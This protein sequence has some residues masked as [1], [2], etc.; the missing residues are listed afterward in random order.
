MRFDSPFLA[1][2]QSFRSP[3]GGEKIDAM[4]HL[5]DTKRF[6]RLKDGCLQRKV[7]PGH[8]MPGVAFE[9]DVL[10]DADKLK[11]ESPVKV[12]ARW[13]RQ[14]DASIRLVEALNP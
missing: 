3:D 14:R 13:V 8:I 12:D 2:K 1:L 4:Y 11:S 9:S 7:P 5:V 6:C 10:I